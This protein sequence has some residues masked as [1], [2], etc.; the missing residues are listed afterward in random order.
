MIKRGIIIALFLV[1]ILRN[2]EAQ[3]PAPNECIFGIFPFI[4]PP[5]SDEGR[6][7]TF[8]LNGS[9]NNATV[10]RNNCTVMLCKN[11]APWGYSWFFNLFGKYFSDA[12]LWKGSCR[13]EHKTPVQLEQ[14]ILSYLRNFNIC[15]G[16]GDCTSVPIPPILLPTSP[17]VAGK[18]YVR[19]FMFGQGPTFAE[20]DE[21]NSYCKNNMSMVVKW[22][23]WNPSNPVPP[24][25]GNWR[26]LTPWEADIQRAR[27][28][29]YLQLNVMPVYI[30]WTNSTLSAVVP[31]DMGQFAKNFKDGSAEVGPVIISPEFAYN[32]N[33]LRGPGLIVDSI[34]QIRDN[35]STCLIMLSPPEEDMASLDEVMR[36]PGVK[37]KVDIIGQSWTLSKDDKCSFYSSLK[38][39][40]DFSKAVL[41]KYQKPT[42]W[43][44]LAAANTT[45]QEKT[46]NWTAK[47]IADAF[48]MIYIN[49]PGLVAA[50]G[51]GIGHYEF[52]EGTDP[53]FTCSG[54]GCNY[55]L[56][57]VIGNTEE[58]K[59]PMFNRWFNRCN[60]YYS[61]ETDSAGRVTAMLRVPIVFNYYGDNGSE[62]NVM[63][64]LGP[65]KML[66]P[67]TTPEPAGPIPMPK[68]AETYTCDRCFGNLNAIQTSGY[69]LLPPH[70]WYGPV[71]LN[72]LKLAIE[73]NKVAPSAGMCTD[74]RITIRKQS[75]IAC[76]WDL[77]PLFVRA[78]VDRDSAFNKCAVRYTDISDMSCNDGNVLTISD[79][80]GACPVG[81]TPAGKKPCSFGLMRCE[82]F[83]LTYAAAGPFGCGANFNPF[84]PGMG[85]CCGANELCNDVTKALDWGFSPA[86][87]SYLNLSN[88]ANWMAIPRDRWTVLLTALVIY[89]HHGRT[90]DLDAAFTHWLQTKWCPGL[91]VT[92][93]P[94]QN[95]PR[96]P[97]A[98]DWGPRRTFLW[99]Y[100]SVYNTTGYV[101]QGHASVNYVDDPW[102]TCIS[103][104]NYTPG[105][106]KIGCCGSRSVP[107]TGW[108]TIE[109]SR[110]DYLAPGYVTLSTC[111]RDPECC[112]AAVCP[113]FPSTLSSPPADYRCNSL[114]SKPCCGQS[115]LEHL[116]C[117]EP[118]A[119][120]VFNEYRQLQ[121]ACPTGKFCPP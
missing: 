15:G 60:G 25:V 57:K 34:K 113:Y 121:T 85:V 63:P 115:F 47:D 42:L 58:Q 35:C 52:L 45:N 91:V 83:P 38:R 4:A 1:L 93:Q 46:C 70:S 77:D 24:Y 74:Y 9:S 51:I 65:Y 39:K 82:N 7:Q 97:L 33:N 117:K 98:N 92:P 107:G 80:T 8:T 40:L 20:F 11:A 31:M 48:D 116:C 64:N 22:I 79:P 26:G 56:M 32:L 36:V 68:P 13:F 6:A 16:S 29:C 103:N 101:F 104:P 69:P 49:S 12:T 87:K 55:G 100:C 86:H 30:F 120:Q 109:A 88:K 106:C 5:T 94:F 108:T 54:P 99:D 111:L 62:C 27:A 41:S 118:Y 90:S 53:T 61:A 50:G 21:A 3:Q 19:Y 76:K 119:C 72:D 2:V 89:E 18:D 17:S 44:Y 43:V 81:P 67:T 114:P 10:G 110:F 14:M 96:P 75:E 112:S 66:R 71:F 23:T 84:D 73:E 95:P 28:K 102:N 59:Q 105:D 37:E 78:V